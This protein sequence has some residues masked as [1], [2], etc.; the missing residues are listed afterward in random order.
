MGDAR[1][2]SNDQFGR[3]LEVV[4]TKYDYDLIIKDINEEIDMLERFCRYSPDLKLIIE[5]IIK[6]LEYEK[7]ETYKRFSND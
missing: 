7:S 3:G 4:I 2:W 6:K 5:R 1:N